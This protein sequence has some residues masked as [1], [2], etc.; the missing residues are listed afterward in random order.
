MP[1]GPSHGGRSGGGSHGGGYGGSHG[2]GGYGGPRGGGP[3]PE[4]HHS[5]SGSFVNGMI[6]GMIGMSIA[7]S[8]RE[9][10][11]KRYGIRPSDDEFNSLPRRQK[12]SGYMFVSIIVAFFMICSCMLLVAINGNLKSFNNYVTTMETDWK[13]D[14]KPMLDKVN[15]EGFVNGTDGFYVVEAEFAKRAIEEYGA[16]PTTP[17]YYLDFTR[18]NID[19]YFIVYEYEVDDEDYTGTTYSQFSANVVQSKNGKIKI[20]Y[21]EKNGKHF[22]IN[23][24][25]ELETCQEYLYYKDLI[26]SNKSNKKGAIISLVI[27]VIVLG[28][29][30]TMYV[31]KLKKYY[32]LVASDEEILF[33][34]KQAELEK[35]QAAAK[36]TYSKNNRFC[37][38]CGSKLEPDAVKCSSCGANL[39]K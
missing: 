7:N 3:R 4:P 35:A 11:E 37:R 18:N 31:V 38:Y 20:A 26:K 5:P 22:S 21:F 15:A 23:T 28:L 10:F 25:Y 34:K 24:D 29:L 13:E 2:G 19:W 1:V 8:R 36:E 14:Y 12:P 39:T 27:E 16:N 9:R 32:K 6:G 17:A 30:I 33:Q